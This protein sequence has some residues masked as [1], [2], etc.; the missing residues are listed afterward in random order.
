MTVWQS[1]RFRPGPTSP[2]A[3]RLRAFVVKLRRALR[4]AHGLG[5]SLRVS[6]SSGVCGG[7]D[8]AVNS[9]AGARWMQFGLSTAYE[10]GQWQSSPES[11]EDSTALPKYF[12]SPG[13]PA[14]S[15][16]PS[17][18]EDVLWSE[19]V[20]GEL[21]STRA[22]LRVEWVLRPDPGVPVIDDPNPPSGPVNRDGVRYR[23]LPERTLKD[24]EEGRRIGLR[25]RVQ[26]QILLEPSLAGGETGGHVARL[27]EM[28]SHRVGGNRFV[29]K[30][31]GSPWSILHP[32]TVLTEAELVGLFPPPGASAFPSSAGGSYGRLR[33]W[34][35]RD[36]NGISVGLPIDPSQGR[37]M[38]VLGETG[39]GK[40]S[41]VVRLAWQASRWGSV[42]LFDPVGETARE[43]LA[44][45]S[46][47]RAGDVSWVSPAHGGLT[48]SLLS[49]IASGG[50]NSIARR[51][52]ML[53][54]VVSALR[55]VRAGRYADSSY[56]G[57][58]LEEMLFQAVR[59]TSEW[60]GASLR[61]AE[62]MLT[63]E[64][65][66]WR[67]VPEAAR[68]H[69]IEV[70]RRIE[71]SPQDGD[72]ARRLLSEITRSAVLSEM[73]DAP[74]PTWSISRAVAPRRTTVVS[75]DAA[76]VGESA[77]RYLLAVIL[78]LA[79]NALL[80]REQPTKTFLIL[81]EAQWYAHESVGEMLRLGRRFNLHVW[82]V[83]QSLRSLPEV[84]RDAFATNSADMVLF[85]GDPSDVRDVS[86]WVPQITP[87][88]IMRMSKGEAAVLIDKGSETHWVH[89]S[90]P[91]AGSGDATHFR[92]ASPS[93][94]A[95]A[96]PTQTE[97]TSAVPGDP[98]PPPVD[99]TPLGRL[100]N[101]PLS[102]ALRDL[103]HRGGVSSE[104]RISL[105]ELRAQ[106]PTEIGPADPW[107]RRAGRVLT[108][109]GTLVRTVNGV[110][111]KCWVLSRDRLKGM[112]IPAQSDSRSDDRGKPVGTPKERSS[113]PEAS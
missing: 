16:F 36:L 72:G 2:D 102:E 64:G 71:R 1:Y 68:A 62:Q 30:S 18:V 50:G 95:S 35:G 21:R 22:G 90:S 42:I 94:G 61:V 78:A 84:V 73:L 60:P 76:E 55:R 75:G 47:S 98:P 41:M 54:D 19:T 53:G 109:N 26:G 70:R 86:R 103:L 63:P 66:L 31:V 110:D 99:R 83:T 67:E 46:E 39:M 79:W 97:S 3:E 4:A 34:L 85:R 80:A 49:E 8:V 15:P 43:F 89:L 7:V 82:A 33:L 101:S 10:L 29:C 32:W 74:S 69:V 105:A 48:I 87:E 107:I 111:G 91:R 59:A 81:D 13:G 57:P 40:S 12:V 27:L 92:T 100:E 6:W 45:V 112:L 5:A 44:G 108:E 28:A 88:R 11:E 37:H 51:E 17:E 20:L 93:G 24:L 9:P 96:A 104:L 65:V 106:W 58:R 23:S 77:A 56:W 52:R 14:A 38:L 25:W 113:Q